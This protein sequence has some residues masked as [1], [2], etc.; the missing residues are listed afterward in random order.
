M[1][2]FTG[3]QYLL[4]DVANAYGLDKKKFEERIEWAEANLGTLETLVDAADSKP[5]FLKAVMAIRKAQAGVPSGHLVGFDAVCSG[6]QLMS[7]MTGCEAGARATGLIDP[8][9]RSDAYSSVTEAM[10]ELLGGMGVNVPRKD[11]K[12]AT[13]TS[14]YGSKEEPKK[15]FGE[16]TD[17]LAAFYKAMGVVAP[18]AWSLLEVLL[19]SWQPYALLHAWQLPDGF[20]T[21]IKVMDLIEVRLEIDELDGASFT[22]YYK[23]N[24][25]LPIGHHKAKSNAANVVHSVD[26]YVLR[27]VHR[28]CNYDSEVVTFANSVLLH[29]EMRRQEESLGLARLTQEEEAKEGSRIAYY[30]NLW[31]QTNMADV[32][33]LPY[34]NAVTVKC[35]PNRMLMKLVQ[36]TSA[37]MQHK[38]FEVVT[39]HDEFK[40]HA[41]NMNQLRWHY[42]EIL[43]DLAESTTLD[44]ILSTIHGRKGSMAKLSQDLGQKIRQ[45]NYALC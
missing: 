32:V 7:V 41:N 6:M 38:P 1:K 8:D 45:S 21:K 14:L 18:G 31:K 15:I 28:R 27:S 37:M 9:V 30:V 19:A 39:I 36:L 34:L 5:L 33:I 10:N 23:E 4:I 13:M 11:A 44:F 42:K 12:N 20:Q 17:E 24:V 22:H 3:W 2:T 16:G 25:G 40:C 43:A 29:E 35:L 26:A